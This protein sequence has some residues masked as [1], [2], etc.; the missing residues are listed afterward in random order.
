MKTF[1]SKNCKFTLAAFFLLSITIIISCK[2]DSKIDQGSQKLQCSEINECKNVIY[3]L[4]LDSAD[5]KY[6][7]ISL[8]TKDIVGKETDD[9]DFSMSGIRASSLNANTSLKGRLNFIDIEFDKVSAENILEKFGQKGTFN[10]KFINLTDFGMHH[11]Y[12]DEEGWAN[13]DMSTHLVTPLPNRTV[14][15]ITADTNDTTKH[16]L[17][18]MKIISMYEGCILKP[19]I[20]DKKKVPYLTCRFEEVNIDIDNLIND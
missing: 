7:Y 16:K 14:L 17:F 8:K 19:T 12:G 3:S 20:A 1:F 4:H 10:S 2:K 18:K 11:L 13:Y 6:N 15:L 9:W 5:K